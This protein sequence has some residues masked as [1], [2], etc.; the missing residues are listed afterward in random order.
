MASCCVEQSDDADS[1]PAA[2]A[3]RAIR[4]CTGPHVEK[5]SEH[6]VN[7]AQETARAFR[8]LCGAI[9][10]NKGRI[11]EDFQIRRAI[12]RTVQWPKDCSS[13]KKKIT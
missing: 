4:N 8:S 12:S 11:E 6:H 5:I 7:P 3:T 1:Q 9:G 13:K 10:T 2:T